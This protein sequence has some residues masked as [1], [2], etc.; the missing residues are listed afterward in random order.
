VLLVDLRRRCGWAEP[1]GPA[2]SGRPDDKLR[3]APAD[4]HSQAEDV[5]MALRAFAHPTLAEPETLRTN[6]EF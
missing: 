6:A 2:R 3:E 5:D 1:T 4:L